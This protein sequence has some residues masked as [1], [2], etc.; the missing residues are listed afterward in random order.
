VIRAIVFSSVGF[1]NLFDVDSSE[2]NTV[3][4]RVMVLYGT[5]DVGNRTFRRRF[6]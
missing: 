6:T 1:Q 4:F 3:F 5:N 2:L